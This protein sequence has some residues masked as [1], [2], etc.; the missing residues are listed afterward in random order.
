MPRRLIVVLALL[1]TVAYASTALAAGDD[2]TGHAHMTSLPAASSATPALSSAGHDYHQ[3]GRV[4]I[5]PLPAASNATHELSI[6]GNIIWITQPAANRVLRATITDG[7]VSRLQQFELPVGTLPHGIAPLSGSS[8]WVTLEGT[9]QLVRLDGTGNVTRRIQLPA[10]TGPHGLVRATNGTLWYAGK[11]GNVVGQADPMTRRVTREIHL[12]DGSLPIYVTEGRNHAIWWTELTGS[13]VGRFQNGNVTRV[14]LPNSGP[15][16]A[17][18][19]PIAIESDTRGDV[20]F[21]EEAGNA[22][23]VIP[24]TIAEGTRSNLTTSS[25]RLYPMPNP[26]S[27]PAGLTVT[28]DGTVW[29]QTTHPYGVVRIRDTT[30]EQ[31]DLPYRPIN[32]G[33]TAPLPHRIHVVP[34][35]SLWYTELKGDWLGRIVPRT[36]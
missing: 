16:S 21:S 34:D 10:G 25:I 8:A 18:A 26:A 33:S 22:A 13:R 28:P 11:E 2:Q 15:G 27:M 4:H 35:G 32:G 17:S 5:A 14:L 12:P 1:G 9:D 20:W 36:H 29:V 7:L 24:V 19:R 31:F 6:V 30:V 23:G 3:P